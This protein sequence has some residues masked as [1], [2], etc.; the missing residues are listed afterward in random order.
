VQAHF[1]KRAI[2]SLAVQH[3]ERAVAAS[4]DQ[5]SPNHRAD[6]FEDL[7]LWLPATVVFGML[8]LPPGQKERFRTYATGLTLTSAKMIA[9]GMTCSARLSELLQQFLDGYE[10]RRA[11]SSESTGLIDDIIASQPDG[12]DGLTAREILDF[13]R[14][15]LPAGSDTTIGGLASMFA[16]LV[17]HPDQLALLR[18]NPSLIANTIEE[19]LRWQ[20][21]NQF[22]FRVTTRDTRIGDVEV[23]AG[24]GVVIAEGAANRDPERWDRPHEFDITRKLRP[25]VSFGGGV[26]MCLGSHLGK[27]E[28]GVA[29]RQALQRLPGLRLDEDFAAPRFI[30]CI[31]RT[32][33]AI[34]AAWD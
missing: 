1:G 32:V 29:L 6:L 34:H 2:E 7:A 23:A 19:V 17:T 20:A 16:A 12:P 30:G 22:N 5:I 24:T 27:F 11:A 33:D 9:T 10:P 31:F 13:L 8:G 3:A 26:H 15:L 4:L 28:M 21:P 25:N 14:V 18:E